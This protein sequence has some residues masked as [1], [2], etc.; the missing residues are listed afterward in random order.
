M[1]YNPEGFF[2]GYGAALPEK[3]QTFMLIRITGFYGNYAK[4]QIFN[5]A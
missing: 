4:W 1:N 3:R 2:H 5:V